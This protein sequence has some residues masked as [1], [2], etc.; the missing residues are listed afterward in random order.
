MNLN[1]GVILCEIPE[2]YFLIDFHPFLNIDQLN[3]ITATLFIATQFAVLN[4]MEDD[5]I[6]YRL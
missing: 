2:A 6:V 3:K 4:D 5:T 1:L